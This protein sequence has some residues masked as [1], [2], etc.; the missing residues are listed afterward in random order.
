[1]K[2]NST[3]F[4]YLLLTT[5]GLYFC[6]FNTLNAQTVIWQEDFGDGDIP[7][8]WTNTDASG[9]LTDPWFWTQDFSTVPNQPAFTSQTA[10][11]GF[12]VF[13]SDSIGGLSQSHD[14]RLTTDVIDCSS[15]STVIAHFESQYAYFNGSAQ[16]LLGVST[17]NVN[18]TYYPLFAN[19]PIN[20]ITIPLQV[21]EI[22]ISAQAAGQSTVYL[23]FRWVGNFEYAWRLDDIR[24]QDGLT[25]VLMNDLGLSTAFTPLS[26]ST[27]QDMIDDLTFGAKVSNSGSEN[28]TGINLNTMITDISGSVIY[29]NDIAINTLPSG[30]QDSVLQTTTTLPTFSLGNYKLTYTLTQNET[31][32]TPD[33]NI[34]S[35]D[36]VISDTTFANDDGN[37]TNGIPGGASFDGVGAFKAGNIFHIAKERRASFASFVISNPA[38]IAGETVSMSLYQLD[39]NGDGNI[40]ENG[41][42]VFNTADIAGGLTGFASYV[43]TGSEA[44][45]IPISLALQ[46]ASG[47][48][49]LVDLVA[50]SDYMLVLEY[51]GTDTIFIAATDGLPYSQHSVVTSIPSTDTWS[52]DGYPNGEI[53]V[54]R[55]HTYD[56]LYSNTED[57][58]LNPNNI[59]L[60]P[61]PASDLLTIQLDMDEMIEEGRIQ[62]VNLQGQIIRQIMVSNIQNETIQMNVT[63]LPNGPYFLNL[64]TQKGQVTQ[65]FLKID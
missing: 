49:D 26:Y 27:P 25:G 29:N 41:D 55:L 21:E 20:D 47:P 1:M 15:L 13:D 5:I 38:N 30:Y 39:Q 11:N 19:T 56:P 2:F 42:Q 58:D 59:Q 52:F 61:N 10:L 4:P 24:I 23:Q 17:D 51:G 18:F 37:I 34:F 8:N 36:F 57:V 46:A 43:F 14:V 65:R 22:D 12:M 63:N 45:N 60:M 48:N 31:D 50:D 32:E 40:D 35:F 3:S 62:I 28:Q 64:Q 7:T 33:D 53:P 44:V 6:F 9:Q 54:V 16:P